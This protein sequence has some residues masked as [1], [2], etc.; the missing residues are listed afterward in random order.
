M[1]IIWPPIVLVTTLYCLMT[2]NVDIID[3]AL[4]NVGRE[5]PGF[6]I[7]LLCVIYSWNGI[8]YITRDAGIIHGLGRLFYSLLRR[9][10]PDLKDDE[11]MLGY[12]ATNV[13]VNMMGLDSTA[14]PTDL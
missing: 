8:L 3:D 7:L 11:E 9:L 14:T 5:T 10:S 4:F 6:V 12:V 1:N 13:V 2:G